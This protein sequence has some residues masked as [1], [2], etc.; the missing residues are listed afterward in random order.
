MIRVN[1]RIW[2]THILQRC[3]TSWRLLRDDHLRWWW[4]QCLIECWLVFLR[5]HYNAL[6]EWAFGIACSLL[7]Y[8]CCLL[9]VLLAAIHERHLAG[10]RHTFRGH[11]T[12]CCRQWCVISSW[13]M[14]WQRNEMA[15]QADGS[16]ARC[17]NSKK[18]VQSPEQ[19]EFRQGSNSRNVGADIFISNAIKTFFPPPPP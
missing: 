18:E 17:V 7:P 12:E 11:L 16:L 15:P 4:K 2:P 3:C 13:E 6:S 1:V 5:A 9:M 19:T 10:I 8:P 14:V